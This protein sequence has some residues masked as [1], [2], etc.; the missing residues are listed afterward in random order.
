MKHSD[1]CI[2]SW[3]QA[4]SAKGA[5][6][7]KPVKGKGP[8]RDTEMQVNDEDEIEV[9]TERTS[10]NIDEHSWRFTHT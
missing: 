7:T 6:G 3:M 4:R 9:G 2:L 5:K 10:L 8:D 1:I